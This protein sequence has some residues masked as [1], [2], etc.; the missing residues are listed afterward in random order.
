MSTTNNFSPF[1]L[2]FSFHVHVE[3]SQDNPKSME[4]GFQEVSGITVSMK[5]EEIKS[6]GENRFSYKVPGRVTFDSN[7]ELKRGFVTRNS[8]L[9]QWCLTHFSNGIN[10]LGAS[11]KIT[12]KNIV[13]HL[14][15]DNMESVMAWSFIGAYPVKWEVSGFNAGES[16]IVVESISLA[17][18]YFKV[19]TSDFK[20]DKSN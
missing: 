6:G 11:K 18:L 16:K 8:S 20:I 4:A 10:P 7:L 12:T 9:G 17:Y 14:L 1:A 15:N 2:G 3:G 5:T 19:I 13:V